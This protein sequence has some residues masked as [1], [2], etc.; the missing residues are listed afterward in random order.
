VLLLYFL[1]I[2]SYGI[3]KIVKIA[4]ITII[5]FMMSRKATM[6]KPSLKIGSSFSNLLSSF[7]SFLNDFLI[8]LNFDF[9]A[10][11]DTCNSF[12]FSFY[13]FWSW[14]WSSSIESVLFLFII[15]LQHLNFLKRV[16]I[17]KDLQIGS[18]ERGCAS[19][20]FSQ[21]KSIYEKLHVLLLTYFLPSTLSAYLMRFLLSIK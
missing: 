5:D 4:N 12:F 7:L 21:A 16:N 14:N 13:K 15:N 8:R 20:I 1:K 10:R 19:F 17:G 11:R 9:G 3:D 6:P 2:E 18:P